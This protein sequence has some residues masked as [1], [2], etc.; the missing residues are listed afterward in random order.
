LCQGYVIVIAGGSA[1]TAATNN[2]A[3]AS[4]QLYSPNGL[5][6]QQ[7]APLPA[8]LY[9][10]YLFYFNDKIMMCGHPNNRQCWKYNIRYNEWTASTSSMYGHNYQPYL[11][12]KDKLY[13][14][15]TPGY[16]EVYDDFN[17][18]WDSWASPLVNQGD[19]SCMVAWRDSFILIGGSGNPRGVQ[20]SISSM[21]YVQLLCS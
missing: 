4:F 6:Q 15:H 18:A 10:M 19:W 12:Y 2:A 8:A 5:C 7:L 14:M 13:A 20:V 21:F 16:G 9:D 11:M 1:S 3:T 17:N